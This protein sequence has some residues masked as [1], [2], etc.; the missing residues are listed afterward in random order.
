MSS[1]PDSLGHISQ[2]KSS[3]VIIVIPK[4]TR[5]IKID[6][7]CKCKDYYCNFLPMMFYFFKGNFFHKKTKT[8]NNSSERIKI[9]LENIAMR[10]AWGSKTLFERPNVITASLTPSPDGVKKERQP[11]KSEKEKNPMYSKNF[12]KFSW[13]IECAAKKVP[14]PKKTQDITQIE[15]NKKLSVGLRFGVMVF[16]FPRGSLPENKNTSIK[17]IINKENIKE[18]YG[19]FRLR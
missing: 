17:A 16:N 7:V 19:M 12:E 9:I 6:G 14:A 15:K 3:S 5:D 18:K 1:I 2:I 4:K 13:T 11:I 8:R 10:A